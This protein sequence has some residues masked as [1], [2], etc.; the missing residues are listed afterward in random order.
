MYLLHMTHDINEQPHSWLNG[1]LKRRTVLR[2]G[3]AATTASIAGAGSAFAVG[4]TKSAANIRPEESSEIELLTDAYNVTH[5]FADDM[6]SLFFAQGYDQARDRLWQMELYRL[7]AYTNEELQRLYTPEELG[8]MVTELPEEGQAILQAFADGVNMWIAEAK[9]EDQLPAEY[10]IE[11]IDGLTEPDAWTPIDSAAVIALQIGGFGTTG[12]NELRNAQFLA[13]LD[14]E[15]DSLA[16]AYEVLGDLVWLNVDERHT[17]SISADEKTVDGSE[18]ILPFADVPQEQ[19]DKA[20]AAVDAEP[21]EGTTP[22]GSS[23]RSYL[24]DGALGDKWGSNA[25][26]VH[27]DLTETG[28]SMMFG[29]PSMGFNKPPT[30]HETG[31]HGAGFDVSGIAVPGIPGIVIGRT[32][33]FSWTVNSGKDDQIDTVALELNPD[34]PT[35]FW[36]EDEWVE[37]ECFDAGCRANGMPVIAWNPEENIAWAQRYAAR[38]EDLSAWWDWIRVGTAETLDE[39][40]TLIDGFAF[41]FHFLYADPENIAYYALGKVPDRDDRVDAR[42]P[43][44]GDEYLW[45]VEE[46]ILRTHEERDTWI[47]N[48]EQGYVVAWNNSPAEGWRAGTSRDRWGSIHEVDIMEHFMQ[49][50]LT[51]TGEFTL[52]DVATHNELSATHHRFGA[53]DLIPIV[54]DAATEA[55]QF[56]EMAAELDDWQED[57]CTFATEDGTH[58]PGFAIWEE[59]ESELEALLFDAVLGE[60]AGEMRGRIKPSVMLDIFEGYADFDWCSHVEG[61]DSCDDVILEALSAAQD[62]L[63]TQFESEDPA[64]W[65]L[66][67]QLDDFSPFG[68]AFPNEIPIVN[69]GSWNH[70]VAPGEGLDGAMGVLPPGNSGYVTLAEFMQMEE[71]GPD[72]EPDRLSDQVEMF[73]DFEYKPMPVTR[74][75]VESVE[76]HRDILLETDIE[77]TVDAVET[78]AWVLTETSRGVGRLYAD[79]ETETHNPTLMLASGQR[80]RIKNEGWDTHQLVFGDDAGDPLLSQDGEGSF[81]DDDAVQWVDTGDTV[82]FTLTTDLA[83]ALAEYRCATHGTMTG[84]VEIVAEVGPPQVDVGFAGPPQDITD[85]G[86]YEDIRGD[87]ELEIA[88]VQA[89]FENMDAEEIQAFSTYYNFAGTTDERVNVFDVQGLFTR[90]QQL[91]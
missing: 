44:P 9:A 43:I 66:E 76:E 8:A 50:L 60:L 61:A 3:G 18:E 88:D 25:L 53:R 48:P 80:Y 7:E 68:V 5:I 74:E 22:G 90:L 55:E 89:L 49:E 75:Q 86:L 34:D 21:F 73:A 35:E 38:G 57:D 32:E 71:E 82:E 23:S 81:E 42:L 39:F 26:L 36:W 58:Y 64:D 67:Q 59:V 29:G 47:R 4:A 65:R 52:D 12:G 11:A 46:D 31:L 62:S 83:E 40:E 28:T 16:E 14:E 24:P 15:M 79:G 69:R 33:Q 45:D 41:S 72:A 77:C 54:T 13:Q 78:D 87:G 70:V 2:A 37:M 91:D 84:D 20:L 85:D 10:E 17:P 30:I 27:G 6:Y 63:E 56:T 51:E 19:L 1:G